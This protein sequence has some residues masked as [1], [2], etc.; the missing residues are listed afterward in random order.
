MRDN[1]IG[2]L[3]ADMK[4]LF[5]PYFKTTDNRSQVMNVSS[6]GLGLSICKKISNALGGDITVESQYGEGSEFTFSFDAKKVI[7][8]PKK[9]NSEKNEKNLSDEEQVDKL[10]KKLKASCKKH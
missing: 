10:R 2:I 8:V 5:K 7:D 4:N 3:E 1:G 9:E 6:H